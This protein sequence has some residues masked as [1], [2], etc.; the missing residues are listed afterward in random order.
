MNRSRFDCVSRD[1]IKRLACR[2]SSTTIATDEA[3]HYASYKAALDTLRAAK[4]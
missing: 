4:T 3:D 2:T 1:A